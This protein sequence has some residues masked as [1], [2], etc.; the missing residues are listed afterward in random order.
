MVVVDLLS[1]RPQHT[2]DYV[3]PALILLTGW[4]VGRLVHG[5]ASVARRLEAQTRQLE[6]ER[7]ELAQAAVLRERSR[8][9]RELHDVVAHSVSVMV[10]QAGAARR[11]LPRS[12]EESASALRTV[13]DVGREA[14]EDLRRTLGFL[15]PA[16][17]A[18]MREP[19]PGLD[20]LDEL[21][22]RA[23]RAGLPVAVRVEGEPWALSPALSLAAYRIVQEAL[24]NTI[25]HAGGAHAAVE[26]RWRPDALE[27]DVRDTGAGPSPAPLPS[28]GQG[29]VGMRER[30]ALAGGTLEAGPVRGG[31]FRVRAR[32]PRPP[33]AP[34]QEPPPSVPRP[35]EAQ[36]A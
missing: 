14:L 17:A 10:V 24:T 11:V 5:R 8:I 30:A 22:E 9:A 35:E 4:F 27:L 21:A 15:R 16:G 7:E 34:E 19:A 36:P 32:L 2:G 33:E 3:F 28:S 12:P 6:R 31:G 26:L 29:L 20:R 23:R 1:E 25:K 18:P 13:Q